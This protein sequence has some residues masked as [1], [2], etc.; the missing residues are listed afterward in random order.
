[1]VHTHM[2]YQLQYPSYDSFI[3]GL[4]DKCCWH[5]AEKL[6]KTL[7]TGWVNRIIAGYISPNSS[8]ASSLLLD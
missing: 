3:E 2:G 4:Q 5:D 8:S 1:M 6:Y 7:V